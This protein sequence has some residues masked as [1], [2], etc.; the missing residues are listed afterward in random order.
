[1]GLALSNLDKPLTDQELVRAFD[2]SRTTIQSW[3]SKGMPND[4]LA[5][6]NKWV[7]ERKIPKLVEV[8][9]AVTDKNLWGKSDWEVEKL[10]LTCQRIQHEHDVEVG[11]LH[12]KQKC[13]NSLMEIRAI[14]SR[15]LH[16][17]GAKIASQFPEIGAKLKEA[18]DKEVDAIVER[19]KDRRT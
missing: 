8:D 15:T 13:A 11:K 1:M 3:R 9:R 6:A 16:G 12:D 5:S 10:R 14:E 2:V 18:I 19:L 17:L 7:M 4:T